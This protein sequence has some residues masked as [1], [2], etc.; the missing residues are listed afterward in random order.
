MDRAQFG[1][2]LDKIPVIGT[3]RSINA[4]MKGP[5]PSWKYFSRADFNKVALVFAGS[6]ALAA[7]TPPSSES[8]EPIYGV[9]E[10][11]S[12]RILSGSGGEYKIQKIKV[13]SLRPLAGYDAQVEQTLDDIESVIKLQKKTADGSWRDVLIPGSLVTKP[14][15]N[16]FNSLLGDNPDPKEKAA[17]NATL[18]DPSIS[19]NQKWSDLAPYIKVPISDEDVVRKLDWLYSM[20]GL[21]GDVPDNAP[22]DLIFDA[23]SAANPEVLSDY[24]SIL[25]AA[26][27]TGTQMG[28]FVPKDKETKSTKE[29]LSQM[30][31]QVPN[32]ET[33]RPRMYVSTFVLQK[34]PEK[35]GGEPKI[36]R[37]K[38]LHV[39]YGKDDER[40]KTFDS[41]GGDLEKP[42]NLVPSVLPIDILAKTGDLGSIVET[43]EI[44]RDMIDFAFVPRGRSDYKGEI[45]P[46]IFIDDPNDVYKS[47]VY[48]PEDNKVVDR[49]D[50][51]KSSWISKVSHTV[52]MLRQLG[53]DSAFKYGLLPAKMAFER[54]FK[55]GKLDEASG[56]MQLPSLAL[57]PEDQNLVNTLATLYMQGNIVN[58][59]GTVLYQGEP[60]NDPTVPVNNFEGK[61]NA[62]NMFENMAWG[63]QAGAVEAGGFFNLLEIM[64]MGN[65]N[66][67][68]YYSNKEG[69]ALSKEV[70]GIGGRL[71]D[72]M[73]RVMVMGTKDELAE[74]MKTLGKIAPWAL[75]AIA[76][77]TPAGKATQGVWKVLTWIA[78]KL[79]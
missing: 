25:Q 1:K 76:L 42:E 46:V 77:F 51:D 79:I 48:L 53:V 24:G 21:L 20:E 23:R 60:E 75:S 17:F 55:G 73:D 56:Q 9:A 62:L 61:E 5:P 10:V 57:F 43:H 74:T 36:I 30:F 31:L 22:W 14:I 18:F 72:L 67:V 63:G 65:E 7:C 38:R 69:N 59:W 64:K 27:Y 6:L 13:D 52:N 50:P 54:I 26:R 37:S 58:Q 15:I 45:K 41:V 78:S 39:L 11:E 16:E 47:K 3:A 29:E 35:E 44:N 8:G 33:D 19:A 40:N 70:K 34:P 32:P 28:I 49:V 71:E 66:V 12:E 4:A 2:F 68:A